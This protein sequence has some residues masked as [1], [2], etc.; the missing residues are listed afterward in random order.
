[1]SQRILALVSVTPSPP[2]VVGTATE[3]EA[4]GWDDHAR[5][6][7]VISPEDGLFTN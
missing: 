7:G 3:D 1:M 5:S 6:A 4:I 2:P